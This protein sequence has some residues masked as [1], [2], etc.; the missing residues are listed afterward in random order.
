MLA[1]MPELPEIETV[2][3]SL[4]P[5]LVG[6]KLTGAV[7]RRAGLRSPF[8]DFSCIIGRKV[9]YVERRSKY[10]RIGFSN[11]ELLVHLGMSG[12]LRW[13][14]KDEPAEKH[15]HLDLVFG[16]QRVRLRDPRRFGAVV[17]QPKGSL[18]SSLARL[19]P[20]PLDEA[21]TGAVLHQR[22]MNRGTPIKVA[23]MDPQV[24]VGVGNIYAT[25]ALF[26]ARIDPRKSANALTSRQ[27]MTLVKHVKDVL[28]EGIAKGG[29]TLRDFH[30]VEGQVGTFAHGMQVYGRAGED[31]D[32][33]GTCIKTTRLGGR[34]SAW[35][36]ACQR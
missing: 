2:K 28:E 26:R 27:C 21:F 14:D 15:D 18:H 24:V 29:S 11:G 10:L 25:E 23:L 36:P 4:G 8:P 32:A 33:C 16:R 31:C 12:S 17:F 1:N 35:C 13:L 6:K 5:R 19:G 22:L 3:R 20:E 7:A 30:G 34:A 9:E